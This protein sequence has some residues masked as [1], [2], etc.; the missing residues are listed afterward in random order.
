VAI[1]SIGALNGWT[2]LMGQVP[3]A[4]AEDQLFPDLFARRS[5]RGVPAIGVVVSAALATG[6]VLVGTSGGA[7]F[8]K[9]YALIVSLSTLT[10]AIPYAFCALASV[11]ISTRIPSAAR[12]RV[13]VVEVVAFLFAIFVIYGC[14]PTA[15]LYGLLLLLLGLPVYVWQRQRQVAAELGQ[16]TPAPPKPIPARKAG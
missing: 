7:A 14:G 10:A 6:L 4:A 11:L 16:W 8:A 15:V 1:S 2:L 9:V 3:M 5:S 12:R 13:T